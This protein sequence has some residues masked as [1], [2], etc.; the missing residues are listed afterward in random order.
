MRNQ[1]VAE[2]FVCGK[3][4]KGS[5]M[6]TDGDKLFSWQTIIA[7]R[8]ANGFIYNGCKYS[9]STSRHQSHLRSALQGYRYTEITEGV[10]RGER[11]LTKY[12]N[13][14]RKGAA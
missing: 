2:M 1:E 5:N 8:T 6:Y 7:Q 3:P 9:V 12:T 13:R 4:A 11:D 10:S 14:K